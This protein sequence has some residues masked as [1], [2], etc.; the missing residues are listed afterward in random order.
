MPVLPGTKVQPCSSGDRLRFPSP[1]VTLGGFL[2]FRRGDGPPSEFHGRPTTLMTVSCGYDARSY[3]LLEWKKTYSVQELQHG[4]A[5]ILGVFDFSDSA[6]VAS[7]LF[8]G[9]ERDFPARCRPSL[10]TISW[11][12]P[13]G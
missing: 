11:E 13:E 8:G 6:V 2:E 3:F 12:D 9:N 4:L 1:P 7:E 5:L 10:G